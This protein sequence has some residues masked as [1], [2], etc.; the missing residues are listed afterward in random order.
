MA[1]TQSLSQSRSIGRLA[2]AVRPADGNDHVEALEERTSART[3]VERQFGHNTPPKGLDG[4]RALL[5]Y[6]RGFKVGTPCSSLPQ[7][8]HW[9]FAGALGSKCKVLV[10]DGS[11][12]GNLLRP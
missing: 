7:R 1:N 11:L 4:A 5:E 3:S 10:P 8:E 6:L 9:A 2:C 12:T